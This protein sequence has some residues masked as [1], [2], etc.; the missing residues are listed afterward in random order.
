MAYFSGLPTGIED[1][2]KQEEESET[3]LS[4]ERLQYRLVVVLSLA[5][6]ENMP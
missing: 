1:M 5:A 2:D 6:L 3:E 4:E